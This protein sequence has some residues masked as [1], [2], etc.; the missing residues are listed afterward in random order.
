MD[1]DIVFVCAGQDGIDIYNNSNSESAVK[2]IS[3]I[4]KGFFK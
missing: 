3:V 2:L 4:D 1:E